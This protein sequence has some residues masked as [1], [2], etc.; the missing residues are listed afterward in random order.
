LMVLHKINYSTKVDLFQRFC[1]DLQLSLST[2]NETYI[3]LISKLKEVG[4]LRNIVVH[5]DWES[6]DEEGF[7]F[8]RVQI[9]KGGIK[10]EYIQFSEESLNKIIKL[11]GDTR[12][13][14]DAYWEKRGEI[15]ANW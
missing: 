12:N 6:T 14:L 5:A 13:Q 9:K 15:L 7:T 8:V 4:K 2:E 3:G 11:I 10:Q 1:D